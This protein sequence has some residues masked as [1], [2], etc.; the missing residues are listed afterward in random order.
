MPVHCMKS[1]CLFNLETHICV[2]ILRAENNLII[3]TVPH[4]I[5]EMY[6]HNKMDNICTTYFIHYIFKC[7]WSSIDSVSFKVS[8]LFLTRPTLLN[9]LIAIDYFYIA[10]YSYPSYPT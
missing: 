1:V 9:E 5:S 2:R 7:F 10:T 4:A 6:T 3:K 8:F